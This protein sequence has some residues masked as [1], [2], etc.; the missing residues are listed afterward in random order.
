MCKFS[1]PELALV[2]LTMSPC[3]TYGI[4]SQTHHFFIRVEDVDGDID[5]RPFYLTVVMEDAGAPGAAPDNV[6][7]TPLA[8]GPVQLTW[9]D[10]AADEEGYRIERRPSGGQW[11][12][13]GE[14]GPNSHS[15]ADLTGDSGQAYEYRVLTLHGG[16][17]TAPSIEVEATLSSAPKIPV[18]DAYDAWAEENFDSAPMAL[19]DMN[20]DPDGDGWTNFFEFAMDLDPESNG[21]DQPMRM[22][23]ADNLDR[24][25]LRFEFRK[26]NGAVEGV[27]YGVETSSNLTQWGVG[28][29]VENVAD[30]ADGSQT[31]TVSVDISE[32][33]A[34]FRTTAEPAE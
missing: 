8:S 1:F 9:N 25:V 11:E 6:I 3:F 5:E 2:A 24:Q 33:P 19:Q 7:A 28:G 27:N 31:V 15:F 14:V 13:L 23:P 32:G 10:A 16:G 30:H 12:T 29:V 22:L 34:F 26:G 18:A 17:Q 4:S 20:A 21:R